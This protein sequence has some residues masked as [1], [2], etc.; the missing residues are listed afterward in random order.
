MSDL[1]FKE[2]RKAAGLTQEQLA[3]LMGVTP[4][5]IINYEKSGSVPHSQMQLLSQIYKKHTSEVEVKGHFEIIT[6]ENNNANS[7]VLLENGQYLMTMP[8]AEFNVQAGFLDHFQDAD[9]LSEMDKH[10]IIV[11]KPAM[12]RYIAFR[13]KGESMDNGTSDSIQPNSIV[14]TRE[15]QRHHWTSKLRFKDFPYWVIYTTHTK[16]PLIKEITQHDVNKGTIKCHSLNEDPGYVDFELSL[17]DVQALFYVIAVTK[18]T[19]I[20]DT[21]Y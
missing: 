6:L 4:R 5:T 20:S 1:S 14:A 9:Y 7:F 11:N 8:L 21:Y 19:T 13:V 18:H 16:T 2:M 17:N 12:G 10:S 3:D 15:L